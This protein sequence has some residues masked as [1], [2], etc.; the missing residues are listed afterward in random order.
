VECERYTRKDRDHRAKKWNGLA[1]ASQLL[2]GRKGLYVLT[3]SKEAKNAIISELSQWRG[4]WRDT[5]R[6]TEVH[7]SSAHEVLVQGKG[8]WSYERQF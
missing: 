7:V 5:S 1:Q 2:S 3:P 8:L 6:G 4:E